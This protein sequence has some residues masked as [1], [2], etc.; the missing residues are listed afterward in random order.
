VGE[1]YPIHGLLLDSPVPLPLD[2]QPD[3]HRSG[4]CVAY[5]RC[6][7]EAPS[8][9]LA[10]TTRVDRP[11]SPWAIER[12][13]EGYVLV[14]FPDWA[15]FEVRADEIVLI[16]QVIADDDLVIHLL[17]DHVVP[18][19]VA[20]RGHL[21]LHASGVVGPSGHAHLFLGPTGTGKSTLATSLSQRGWELL[22]DDGVRVSDRN[23]RWSATPGYAGVRLLPDAADALAPGVAGTPMARGHQKL[24]FRVADLGIRMADEAA[25]IAAAYVLRWDES[26]DE[27][28]LGHLGFAA[29]VRA[30]AGHAFHFTLDPSELAR[31][32]FERSSS[33]ASQVQVCELVQPWTSEDTRAV[34]GLLADADAQL[35]G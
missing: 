4:E 29:G 21:M 33:F 34:V 8:A 24:R 31:S 9:K 6:L 27:P 25:P 26:V 18:R 7:R 23:G 28:Q 10:L 12:W 3:I 14:E 22:D 13:Y 16:E 1:R 5:R 19:V 32:A 15:T 30:V 35:G 17:L 2:P 11:E 20:L